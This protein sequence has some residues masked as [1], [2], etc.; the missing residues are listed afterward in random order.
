MF[1]P[2]IGQEPPA[3]AYVE[4]ISRLTDPRE[5]RRDFLISLAVFSSSI[6]GVVTFMLKSLESRRPTVYLLEQFLDEMLLPHHVYP[7]NAQLLI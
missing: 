6:Q 7:D 2:S 4:F 1:C 5:S 3:R